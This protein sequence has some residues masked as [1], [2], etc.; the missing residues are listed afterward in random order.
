M[1]PSQFRQA[2]ETFFAGGRE[3]DACG[4]LR[5]PAGSDTTAQMKAG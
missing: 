5:L 2:L 1:M 3:P 4:G